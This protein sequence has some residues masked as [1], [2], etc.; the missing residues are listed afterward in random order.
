MSV[1]I[2]PGGPADAD[3][4]LALWRDADAEPTATDDI[5]GIDRLLHHDP[6]ALI[7]AEAEGRIVGS[8]IAGW[9]GWRGSIYRLAVAPDHRRKG[10]ANRLLAAAESQLAAKG[11]V[12]AQAIVVETN[13]RATSFWR[14]TAWHEQVERLRFVSSLSR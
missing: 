6:G 4:V 1:T 13:A 8:V 5:A 3:A 14:S 2:R 11:A 7:V 10:V 12:R 9:D